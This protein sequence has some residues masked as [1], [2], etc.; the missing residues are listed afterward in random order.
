MTASVSKFG[1]VDG[2]CDALIRSGFGPYLG[3]PCGILSPLYAALADRGGL[4][5]IGREDNAVAVAG[6]MSLAGRHPVVLMQNSGLGNSVNVLA[7]L[8]VPYRIPMLLVVS[9]RGIDEDPTQE[10]QVMGQL[11]IPL[12]EGMGIETMTFEPTRSSAVQVD[13]ARRVVADERRPM[14]LL[15]RPAA[16][17]WQA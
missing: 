5:T 7:S 16:F 4:L 2:L 17:G 8:V 15:V 12:L 11:T 10:N 13:R 6:G 3:T 14:V 9:M 1:V